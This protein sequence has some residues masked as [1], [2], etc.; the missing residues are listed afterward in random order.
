MLSI[1]E[2]VVKNVPCTKLVVQQVFIHN[3]T[4]HVCISTEIKEE[5]FVSRDAKNYRN[6]IL[7]VLQHKLQQRNC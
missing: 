5:Y 7:P 3:S 1:W 4:S 6:V 2:M